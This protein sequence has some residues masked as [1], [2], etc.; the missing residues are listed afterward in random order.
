MRVF[1]GLKVLDVAGYIAAPGA[2]TILS[3]FGADVIK[4]EAPGDGDPF[5]KVYR[6]PNQAI[7]DH[8]YLWTMAARNR[9]ALALNLKRPEGQQVLQRLVQAA[10]VL[11]TNYPPHVRGS[12]GLTYEQLNG[13]NPRLIYA[14]FTGYGETGPEAAK[15]G[16]DATAYWSRSGLADLVR[17]DPDG[18]PASA[19]N[20]MGDQ[21]SGGMLYGAIVTALYRRERTGQGGMV[22][23][24]LI[25][26]GAWANAMSIQAALV[27]GEVVYR[28][29]RQ[30]P[31][32]ALANY[33]RC[34]DARWFIL[35][36]IAE[37]RMWPSFAALVGLSHLLSDPRFI[38]SPA[39]REHAAELAAQLDGAFAQ[40]D[41]DAWQSLFED[42]GHTVGIVARSA[43][44]LHDEQMRIAG[45]LVPGDGIPGSG[46]TVD[47]PFRLSDENKVRPRPAPAVGQH[48]DEIL[49]AHGYDAEA[50]RQL[51][52]SGVVG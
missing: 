46:L 39:R 8:N 49:Q 17:P 20:G 16:F 42:A 30:R 2:A 29:P 26:N 5:R 52:D 11:I 31:R 22:S 45:A 41:S 38:D 44:A 32:N 37:E 25:A 40:R 14:S 51:R 48:S 9:R 24:S 21:P 23:S 13:L 35:S 34:R 43:D 1:D 27:G 19:A 6:M 18:P 28:Q 15:P 33:Y 36:L 3:D 7:S 50:I 10:D 47:S 4:I 12:L